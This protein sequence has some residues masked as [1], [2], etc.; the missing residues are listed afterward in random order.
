MCDLSHGPDPRGRGSVGSV[1]Q[2]DCPGQG[3][4]F[5]KPLARPEHLSPQYLSG[6]PQDPDLEDTE[7][8]RPN[9]RLPAGEIDPSGP[10][11]FDQGTDGI[12][13]EWKR[14]SNGSAKV[15]HPGRSEPVTPPSKIGIEYLDLLVCGAGLVWSRGL[16]W[17]LAP[18]RPPLGRGNAP[19]NQDTRNQKVLT[20]CA[21]GS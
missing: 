12:P 2:I 13:A 4:E 9:C 21:P 15:N 19:T 14:V 3:S 1:R 7:L 6:V 8:V 20:H 5:F 18:P 16:S 10:S 11:A 17:Q